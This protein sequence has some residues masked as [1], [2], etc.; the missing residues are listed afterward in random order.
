MGLFSKKPQRLIE[1]EITV[2]CDYF[3][4]KT[5]ENIIKK[6]KEIREALPDHELRVKIR[7]R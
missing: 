3:L 5:N 4:G 1:L 2:S 6:I 7:N